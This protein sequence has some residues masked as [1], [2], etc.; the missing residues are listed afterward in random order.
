[1]TSKRLWPTQAKRLNRIQ[2]NSLYPAKKQL[3]ILRGY[4]ILIPATTKIS[5]QSSRSSMENECG[6]ERSGEMKPILKWTGLSLMGFVL[7]S[8]V[9]PAQKKSAYA[10][11]SDEARTRGLFVNKR[12]DAMRFVLLKSE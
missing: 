2:E 3:V 8:G 9:S 12:A 6:K 10:Q 11:R 7:L 1:M 4:K 5:L